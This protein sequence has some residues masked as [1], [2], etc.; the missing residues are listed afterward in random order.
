MDLDQCPECGVS[1]YRQD[2]QGT[3]IPCKVLRHFPLIPRLRHMFRCKSIASLMTWHLKGASKDGKIRIPDDSRAWKPIDTQWPEFS[4]EP[5]NIRLGLATDGV[6]P[7][8]FKSTKWSMWPIV[9]VNYNITPWLCI[10]KGHIILS[11]IIPGKRKPS[12]LQVYLAPPLEELQ[13]L[14]T[15]ISFEDK[16][17]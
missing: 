14:W 12:N 2:L 15:G 8:G 9:L 4:Q 17:R 13:T 10:K 6:N 1:R 5:R 16:S 3:N 7:Y 11:L